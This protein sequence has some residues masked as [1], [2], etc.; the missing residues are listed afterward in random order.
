[1]STLF[2][3]ESTL[4]DFAPRYPQAPLCMYDRRRFS[5]RML[6]EAVKTRPK[7]LLDNCL[8]ENIWY[9]APTRAWSLG[10]PAARH[11][12]IGM[13]SQPPALTQAGRHYQRTS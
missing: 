7:I 6:F 8:I 11:S 12:R 2:T 4:N 10:G 3:Y 1:M 5:G 13:P 9:I